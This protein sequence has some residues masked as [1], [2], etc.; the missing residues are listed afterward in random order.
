M[1]NTNNQL[2]SR[3][4][5]EQA[6]GY[7]LIVYDTGNTGPSG[8]MIPDGSDDDAKKVDQVNWF[9]N[10]LAQA[11]ISEAN[12][13]T[14]WLVGSNVLE[15]NPT[16]PLFVTTMATSMASTDQG[17]NS[18]PDALGQTA[19]TFD[20]GGGGNSVDFSTGP[21]SEY[22]LN[23][24][25]PVIRN[26]DGQASSG[27][28]VDVYLYADPNSGATGDAAVVMNSNPAANWNTIMMS[29]PWFDI[30][31]DFGEAPASLTSGEDLVKSFLDN[32]LPGLCIRGIDPTDVGGQDEIDAPR[33]T[34]LHL[35][36][37]NPFNPTTTI[38][39]DLAQSGHVSLK[40]YDVAGRLVRSLIDEKM[41]AD[42]NILRVWD[43]MDNSGQ[44][45]SSGVYFYRLDAPNFSAVNKMVMM[46]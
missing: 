27:S 21:K 23:G 19:F 25:C 15:E 26:Y 16:S 36:R 22:S 6:T 38:S 20:V 32:A 37:P 41:T 31:E 2:G 3:A 42:R 44:R 17:L 1:G 43:G 28:G 11:S 33:Q 40:I 4:T 34:V 5:I 7:N 8:T 35:N 18:N 14:L 9:I 30:R 29:H 46:K 39:F 12:F 13:A 45:T 24:G 10:W